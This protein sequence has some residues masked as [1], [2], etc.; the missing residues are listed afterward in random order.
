MN[1]RKLHLLK[2]TVYSY[3]HSNPWLVKTE[4]IYYRLSRTQFCQKHVWPVVPVPVGG[5]W[6]G[7]RDITDPVFLSSV[8]S[9]GVLWWEKLGSINTTQKAT[10][11]RWLCLISD[12]ISCALPIQMP[13]TAE[14]WLP[15]GVS[16]NEGPEEMVDTRPI[17]K[18]EE[19]S[20]S[21]LLPFPFF[22]LSISL[23]FPHFPDSFSSL[24]ISSVGSLWNGL[25][26]HQD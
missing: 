15:G 20:S 9:S 21:F 22:P 1:H 13:A 3:P 8:P 17:W 7:D 6:G 16:V 10:F 26:S 14:G 2:P 12:K 23:S 11:L 19:R 5:W 4:L 25:A 24:A 18:N